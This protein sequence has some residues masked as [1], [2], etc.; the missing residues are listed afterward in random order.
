[1]SK[2]AAIQMASGP[3]V[4]ANLEEAERLIA[5]AADA[6]AKLVVLPENFAIMGMQES[7]K[8]EG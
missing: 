7:D 3:Q 2:V 8:I 5:M 4:V 6:G 1:V